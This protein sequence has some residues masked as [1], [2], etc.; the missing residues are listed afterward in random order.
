MRPPHTAEKLASIL[1]VVVNDNDHACWLRLLRFSSSCL[2]IP[3]RQKCSKHPSLTSL[4]QLAKHV[5][6][7]LDEG[8]F[9]GALRLA[10]SSYTIA[11]RYNAT[12]EALKKNILHPTK[13]LPFP[14]WVEI[15]HPSLYLRKRSLVLSGPSQ[16]VLQGVLI[17]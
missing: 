14:L 16:M 4:A 1:N 17:A 7:K 2:H 9:K 11:D 10:C 8:D 15:N 5:S 6:A 3:Q 12:L 13:I